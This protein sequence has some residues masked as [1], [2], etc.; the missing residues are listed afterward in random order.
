MTAIKEECFRRQWCDNGCRWKQQMA[1][2]RDTLQKR[3][4][5]R[6]FPF[7]LEHSKITNLSSRKLNVICTIPADLIPLMPTPVFSRCRHEEAHQPT[8]EHFKGRNRGADSCCVWIWE[9]WV[10]NGRPNI[11]C[12][13]NQTSRKCLTLSSGNSAE[14]GIAAVI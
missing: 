9:F 10:A 4:K 2:F 11:G 13:A 5:M 7:Y 12:M 1:R 8:I 6:L 3:T 14:A